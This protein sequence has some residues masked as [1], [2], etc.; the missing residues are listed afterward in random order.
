[1]E[2]LHHSCKRKIHGTKP[3]DGKN[4][5]RINDER[6]AGDSQDGWNR[7][8][9]KKNV[10][11]FHHQQNHKQGRCKGLPF[12]TD[13]KVLSLI[14]IGEREES[15]AEF[16]DYIFGGILLFI[17]STH[18]LKAG[19]DQKDSEDVENPMEALHQRH[20]GYDKDTAHNQCANNSPEQHALFFFRRNFKIS[21]Q[22]DENK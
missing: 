15:S 6:V 13:K 1:M 14:G 8:R 19:P 5:R 17:A 11:S 10:S 22:Q 9:G 3:Q 2:Q 4:V 21:E 7:V 18:E 20:A 12:S 16:Q